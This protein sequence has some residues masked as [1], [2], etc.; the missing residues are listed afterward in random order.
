MDVH[1]NE[2]PPC[3]PGGYPSKPNANGGMHANEKKAPGVVATANAMPVK[4]QPVVATA[5]AMQPCC[6]AV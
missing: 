2:I 1:G 6:L 5:N 3:G 4:Y